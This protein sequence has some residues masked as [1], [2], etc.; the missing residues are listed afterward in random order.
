MPRVVGLPRSHLLPKQRVYRGVD[1]QGVLLPTPAVAPA[2]VLPVAA[3]PFPSARNRETA[4]TCIGAASVIP[5]GFRSASARISETANDRGGKNPHT[6][7][8]PSPARTDTGSWP[9]SSAF[10]PASLPRSPRIPTSRASSP[11]VAG[12]RKRLDF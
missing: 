3:T 12:R 7:P 11:P 8:A 6:T 4:R 10:P 2:A 1:I 5:S 9:A